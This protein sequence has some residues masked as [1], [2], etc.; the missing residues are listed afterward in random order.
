[1]LIREYE[2]E[3]DAPGVRACWIELQEFER[4]LDARVPAGSASVEE[5]L[6]RLFARCRA[7]D[8]RLF[9]AERDGELL[10][11]VSVLAAMRSEEPDDDPTPYAYVTDLVVLPDHR[12]GGLGR[13]LLTRAER[14]ARERG[15][16]SLRLRVKGGNQH[17]RA[18]YATSGYSEYELELEKQL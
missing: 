3:R 11:F 12:G 7:C 5:Y 1:M 13:A 2:A 4:A 8:G 10:G 16:A 18:Y 9:V 6:D 15:T 14:Y 17:A